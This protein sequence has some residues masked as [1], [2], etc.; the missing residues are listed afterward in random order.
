LYSIQTA[1]L[2]FT[3]SRLNQQSCHTKHLK[4]NLES[5]TSTM[6]HT[7]GADLSTNQNQRN[8]KNLFMVLFL[9]VLDSS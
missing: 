6:E 3:T 9:N 2:Q 4:S 7:I 8:L 5:Q 1:I